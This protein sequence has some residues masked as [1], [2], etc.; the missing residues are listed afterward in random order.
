LSDADLAHTPEPNPIYF[1]VLR[2]VLVQYSSDWAFPVALLTT[3]LMGWITWLGIRSYQVRPL[4]VVKGAIILIGSAT[5]APLL[6]QILWLAVSR[7]VVRD[8]H[9]EEQ[10]FVYQIAME[11]I[12]VC[13]STA[14]VLVWRRLM[15]MRAALTPGES[16]TGLT[17]LLVAMGAAVSI[18]LPGFS[19]LFAWPLL[20]T[21]FAL[22]CRFQSSSRVRS[23]TVAFCRVPLLIASAATVLTWI[24]RLLIDMFDLDMSK[25]YLVA[26]WVVL[27]LALAMSQFDLLSTLGGTDKP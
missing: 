13:T 15:G 21:V 18:F 23:L 7:V 20:F 1:D 2:S 6:V 3:L 19:Y 8:K 22:G 9:F 5:T 16:A 25:S 14:V 4:G 17:A 12:F 10:S 11:F 24:P 26:V 27:F